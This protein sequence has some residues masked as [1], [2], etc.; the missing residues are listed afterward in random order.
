[1]ICPYCQKEAE[2]G[3]IEVG[4]TEMNWKPKKNRAFFLVQ[5]GISG[6]RCGFVPFLHQKLPE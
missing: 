5:R 1:M 6:G 2:H 3:W 4:S